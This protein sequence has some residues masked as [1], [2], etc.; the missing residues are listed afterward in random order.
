MAH[1]TRREAVKSENMVFFVDGAETEGVGSMNLDV[2]KIKPGSGRTLCG[3]DFCVRSSPWF[4]CLLWYR[5][6]TIDL[7]SSLRELAR[8]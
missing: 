2:R 1:P 7:I 5:N 3:C 6:N 4:K 8:A